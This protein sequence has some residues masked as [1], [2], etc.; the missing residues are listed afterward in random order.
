[1]LSFV[2]GDANSKIFIAQLLEYYHE[3]KFPVDKLIKYY[4]F[5]DINKAFKE[6]HEGIA[7]KSVLRM[8]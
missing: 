8:K 4:D 1:M 2:E 7:I 6:S 5:E 3:G